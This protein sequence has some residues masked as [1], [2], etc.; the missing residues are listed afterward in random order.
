MTTMHPRSSLNRLGKGL[1]RLEAV[2]K[3]TGRADYTHHVALPGMLYAKIVRSH[4]AHGRLR[5]VHVDDALAVPGVHGVYT[6]ADI[7][8]IIPEPYYGPAFHDQPILAIDKVRYVGEPVAVV[9]AESPHVAEEAAGLVV[10]DIDELPAVLDEVQ[11]MTSDIYVHDSLRPAGTFADLKHLDGIRDT[12]VALTFGVKKGNVDQA[13]RQAHRVFKH[14]FK[15]QQVMHTPLE[16]MVSVAD[17]RHAHAVIYTA[18][19]TPSF[20]RTEIARLLGWRENQVTIKTAFLGGG[21]GCKLYVKLEPLAVALSMLCRRPVR[22]ALTMAEQFYTITRHATTFNIETAVTQEGRI[23]ARRCEVIWNGGAY[24]DIGPRVTQKSGFT[25]PG[26]YN[27]EHVDVTSVAVYTNRPP[28]GAFRGFGIPQLVWA[29]ESQADIIAREMGLDPI[30]FRLRNVLSDGKRHATGTVMKD[31]AI[32]AVLTRLAER[33]G[34]EKGIE[35]G[36]GRMRRGRGIGI[37]IKACVSPTT[38][39]AAISVAADGSCSVQCNTVDMGQGSNTLMAMIVSEVIGVPAESVSVI[40]ADTD[41]SPYDMATLGSRSTFH[42]GHAVRLAAEDALSRLQ[43]MAREVGVEQIDPADLGTL[44]VR[45]FGMQAG[46][47][48]GT[49][50]YKPT[51]QSPDKR[52]GQSEDITPN[53]M[54]GGCAI[55]VEVDTETGMY[56]IL[57]MENVVDCGTALNPLVVQTQISGAAIMQLGTVTLEEMEFDEQGQL[58]NAGLSEYKIAGIQDIPRSIG[59]EAVDAWQANGPFGG[60]GVGESGAFGVAPALASAIEDAVGVRIT[61]LPIRPEKIWEGLRAQQEQHA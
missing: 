25:A 5:G 46:T 45:K 47:V 41:A 14:T 35:R 32:P 8:K 56:T 49:G 2:D 3:V 34:W 20:A 53:W 29:Y 23:V 19:Q 10:A 39:V 38:S 60:K 61:E 1:R 6:G 17:V 50:V 12:N 55:E 57:R 37:G 28:A 4:V 22:V 36:T 27:I 59:R 26:P 51:Y 24:A 7:L 44:F 18:S 40:A 43:A 21:F 11:A 33:F 48:I 52:T 16:P 31:A 9:V 54:I 15:T 13:F 30:E 58:R 42:M